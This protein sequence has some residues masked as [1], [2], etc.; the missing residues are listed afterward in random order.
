MD[1]SFLGRGYHLYVDN[2]YMSP[3]LFRDLY[4][5]GFVAGEVDGHK[6][7]QCALPCTKPL[8]VVTLSPGTCTTRKLGDGRKKTN[9][10][11]RW[12]TTNTCG[13]LDLSDQLLHYYTCFTHT[14]FAVCMRCR[15]SMCYCAFILNLILV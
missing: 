15:R 5:S 11:V 13:V 6:K 10:I 12:T 3:K 2:F 7:C 4:A 14:P 1:P 9:I 8:M